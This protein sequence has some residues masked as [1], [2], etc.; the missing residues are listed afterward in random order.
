MLFSACVTH[1]QI[2]CNLDALKLQIQLALPLVFGY[3]N[4]WEITGLNQDHSTSFL[5]SNHETVE[6]LVNQS[7]HL[8]TSDVTLMGRNEWLG[9]SNIWFL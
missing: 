5:Q 9:V 6:L 4:Q 1:M 8:L 2:W 7:K 3:E